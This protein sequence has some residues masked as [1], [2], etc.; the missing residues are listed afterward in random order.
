VKIPWTVGLTVST[1][2]TPPHSAASV[3]DKRVALLIAH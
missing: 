2:E 3:R 1:S